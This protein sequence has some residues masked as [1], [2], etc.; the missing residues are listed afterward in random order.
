MK[1][2][3]YIS[4]HIKKVPRRL[5]IKTP[6]TFLDMRALNIRNV[7]L[8][9]YRNSRIREKVA[10]ILRKIQTLWVNNSIIL[11]IQNATFTGYYF[12]MNTSIWRDFQ[13]CISVPITFLIHMAKNH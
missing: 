10:Y 1:I 4:L 11:K 12:Y 3:Q 13:I 9:T 5:H 8:Q 7:C 6:F 2:L